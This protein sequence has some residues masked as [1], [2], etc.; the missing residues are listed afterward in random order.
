MIPINAVQIAGMLLHTV[1][2]WKILRRDSQRREH[3]T[4]GPKEK[5]LKL[6]LVVDKK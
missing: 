5:D 1:A 3:S 4:R 6:N 2:S